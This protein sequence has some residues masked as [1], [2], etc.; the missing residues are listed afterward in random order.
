MEIQLDLARLR[1]RKLMVATPLFV[2]SLGYFRSMLR[3]H[4]LFTQYGVAYEVQQLTNQS[5]VALARNKMTDVFLRSDCTDLVSIDND[6]AFDPWD[7]LAFLH[8]D[9]EVIGANCPRKQI[10]WNLV[11]E[12]VLL[13]PSIMPEKL[14]LMGATWM[15]AMSP[16]CKQI[17][18][19]EPLPVDNIPA[20]FSLIKR[21]VFQTLQSRR[22]RFY[23]DD[24]RKIADFWSGGVHEER[25]ETEDYAFSRRWREMGGKV[26]LCPWMILRHEGFYSYPGDMATVLQHFSD[27]KR[28]YSLATA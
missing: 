15:A 11:R 28:V 24:V 14:E 5:D 19:G 21:A 27:H 23:V 26:W 17:K 22:P 3:L 20:G 6:V 2:P 18:I 13:E 8:F 4:S 16:D 25:W 1:Q 10:D 9:K 12:A 7:V